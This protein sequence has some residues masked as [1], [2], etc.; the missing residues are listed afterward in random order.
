MPTHFVLIFVGVLVLILGIAAYGWYAAKKRRE[1][2]TAWA[3]ARGLSFDPARRHGVDDAFPAFDCL[4][5]GRNRYA[6]NTLEGAW[7]DRRFTGFDYHYE[8]Q[9]TDSKGHRRTTHHR[10]SAVILTSS[11]PLKPLFVRPE[12]F[13][14]KVT[15]FFGIDDID[16]ESA[17][18]SRAFYVKAPD[19][20]WAYDVIHQRTMQF[21]LDNPRFSM[22]FD[23]G[24]VIA[25][26]SSRFKVEEFAAAADVVAG[27]LDNL[28]D[29]VV[30][31]QWDRQEEPRQ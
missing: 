15:E 22:K 28:P 1:A 3:A 23:A 12:G 21:L 8:T 26:R 24:R 5:R 20:R 14:D 17:E 11:V 10:F 30:Q 18:F 31:Q 2:M 13:F 9:S 27:L 19:K 16:F 25:W 29:Y 7:G 4:R 6:Y